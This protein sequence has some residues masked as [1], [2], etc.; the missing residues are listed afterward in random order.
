MASHPLQAKPCRQAMHVRTWASAFGGNGQ[1]GDSLWVAA[2]DYAHRCKDKA[3]LRAELQRRVKG[4]PLNMEAVVAHT[5]DEHLYLSVVGDRRVA[6]G[7]PLGRGCVT[8]IGDAAHPTTPALG[9]AR[10]CPPCSQRACLR[11]ACSVK[12]ERQG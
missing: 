5:P 1:R 4:L 10:L 12:A 8:I 6:A 3:V 7:E 2:Q 9:Q 11:L